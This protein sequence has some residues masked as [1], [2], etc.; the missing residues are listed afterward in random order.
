MKLKKSISLFA[1]AIILVFTSGCSDSV[2]NRAYRHLKL[3]REYYD[4][5][6]IYIKKDHKRSLIEYEKAFSVSIKEFMPDDYYAMASLYMEINND[7]QKYNQFMK[8]GNELE[9]KIGDTSF[10]P[11]LLKKMLSE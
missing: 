10:G 3:A 1:I 5:G 4:S 2:V 6:V 7:K 11:A 8:K 9:S